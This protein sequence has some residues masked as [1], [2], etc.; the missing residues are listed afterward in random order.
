MVEVSSTRR[1]ARCPACR[2]CSR[3]A[4]SR[5]TR[6]R[7]DLPVGDCPVRL[8]LHARRFHCSN[9]ACAHRTV[10]QRLPEVAPYDQRRPPALRQRLETVAFA[11][12]GAAGR[13]LVHNFQLAAAGASRHALLCLIR[14]AVLPTAEDIAP[15]L[16][17]G[18]GSGRLCLATRAAL[19]GDPGR[20]RTA[21]RPRSVAR[22][23]SRYRGQLARVACW[24]A[25]SVV[26][27]DRGGAFADGVRQAVPLAIPVA[28]RF[29]LLQ[30]LGPARDR[31]LTHEHR[32]LTHVA[33]AV[34]AVT[35]ARRA[36][37]QCI[38]EV[39]GQAGATAFTLAPGGDDAPPPPP[40]SQPF[41]RLEREHAAVEVRRGGTPTMHA[42]WRW[43]TKDTH[44]ARLPAGPG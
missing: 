38:R 13:R 42:W 18:A 29:H 25:V 44:S 22:P 14:R 17:A 32:V 21:P 15:Q 4:Q 41:T 35:E 19:R 20:S 6:V 40:S 36:A 3:R 12:G 1:T 24:R 8:R 10:R 34:G 39:T 28:D 11:L 43:R 31:V 37:A 26:S 7:A 23:R 9:P 5:F 33:E 27:R 30:H 16:R 2:R